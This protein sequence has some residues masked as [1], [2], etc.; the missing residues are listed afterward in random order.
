MPAVFIRQAAKYFEQYDKSVIAM[1]MNARF[2]KPESTYEIIHEICEDNAEIFRSGHWRKADYKDMMPKLCRF[3]LHLKTIF[4]KAPIDTSLKLGYCQ[5]N[6]AI[7][8]FTA[9][10]RADCK[11]DK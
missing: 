1:A 6:D 9:L 3:V 10:S 4:S 7:R 5:K 2:E 8:I 11:G